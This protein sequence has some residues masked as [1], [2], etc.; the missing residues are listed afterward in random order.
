ML[1]FLVRVL[2]MSLAIVDATLVYVNEVLLTGL[3][4]SVVYAVTVSLVLDRTRDVTS[5]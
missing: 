3:V 4:L 2:L 1:R 5:T